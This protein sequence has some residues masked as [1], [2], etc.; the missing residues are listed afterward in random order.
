MSAGETPLLVRSA[1]FSILLAPFSVLNSV[2]CV[3]VC[4]CVECVQD[5]S[6]TGADI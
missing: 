5:R 2:S 1:S 6:C 4:V 3:C